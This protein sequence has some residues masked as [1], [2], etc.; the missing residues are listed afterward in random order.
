MLFKN[1]YRLLSKLV[2][3]LCTTRVKVRH[4]SHLN[5]YKLKQF[6]DQNRLKVSPTLIK[7]YELVEQELN[8]L[9]TISDKELQELARDE[10]REMGRQLA[11][12]EARIVEH[13]VTDECDDVH[14]CCLD[15]N[16]GVGGQE[17]MLFTKQL[18]DVYI[19]LC[20]HQNCNYSL[21]SNDCDT[22]YGGSRHSSLLISGTDCYRWLRHEAGVHRVQRVSQSTERAD[23]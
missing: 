10:S 14:Q 15:L 3:N 5:S 21:V 17:A 8:E 2:I 11:E 12:I 22:D 16:C 4:K 23:I 18:F 6:L 9:K 19:S 13:C 20:H 1:N 7:N